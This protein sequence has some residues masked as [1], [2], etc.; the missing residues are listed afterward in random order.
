MI[1][2]FSIL[3]QVKEDIGVWL[4]FWAKEHEGISETEFCE[5]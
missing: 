4:P 1:Q 3:V 5:D 2:V